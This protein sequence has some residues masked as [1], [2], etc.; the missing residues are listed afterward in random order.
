[1]ARCCFS[2]N[3]I[4]DIA[5]RAAS[6]E[7]RDNDLWKAFVSNGPPLNDT[8]ARYIVRSELANFQLGIINQVQNQVKYETAYYFGS[9]CGLN[10]LGISLLDKWKVMSMKHEEQVQQQFI[11]HAYELEKLQT[12]AVS[13]TEHDLD[14]LSEK[15]IKSIL[16]T[17]PG[18]LLMTEIDNRVYSGQG[19]YF[20]TNFMTSLIVGGIAGYVGYYVGNSKSKQ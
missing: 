6:K 16:S 13:R 15:K 20:L 18:S 3:E 7:I 1:M 12:N 4:E 19:N 11:S 5:A 10:E 2:R 14:R 8:Q 9:K 17:E